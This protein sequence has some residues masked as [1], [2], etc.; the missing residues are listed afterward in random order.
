[1]R[2]FAANA[3]LWD[4]IR[5]TLPCWLLLGATVDAVI[6]HSRLAGSNLRV[7]VSDQR[8]R[9][10]QK[11]IEIRILKPFVD[12]IFLYKY[13]TNCNLP[14]LLLLPPVPHEQRHLQP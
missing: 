12:L 10:H 7:I 3:H 4:E 2:T 14:S 6:G 1:M 9:R 13:L 8:T 5:C 11:Y